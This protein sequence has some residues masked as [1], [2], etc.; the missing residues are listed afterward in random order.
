MHQFIRFVRTESLQGSVIGFPQSTQK[1]IYFNRTDVCYLH[2]H[3]A[4]TLIIS[5]TIVGSRCHPRTS[6]Q[7]GDL[8]LWFSVF[9]RHG[10]VSRAR[11]ERRVHAQRDAQRD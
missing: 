9:Q 2:I 6:Y 5:L 10:W 1:F 7:L 4:S 11:S 8:F 3:P